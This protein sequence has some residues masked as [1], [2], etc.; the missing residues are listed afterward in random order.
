MI[1]ISDLRFLNVMDCDY[2]RSLFF[3][4]IISA[5]ESSVASLISLLQARGICACK[6]RG[7]ENGR[8]LRQKEEEQR[9]NLNIIDYFK[10]V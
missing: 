4:Y 7:T 2:T 1:G 5:E 9:T 10:F 6:V 8:D 3:I